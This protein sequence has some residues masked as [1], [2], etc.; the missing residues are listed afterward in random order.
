MLKFSYDIPIFN[1][2]KSTNISRALKYF[3]FINFN[4]PLIKMT[5]TY[6]KG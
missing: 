5:E 4:N 6:S 2:F 1:K 3:C